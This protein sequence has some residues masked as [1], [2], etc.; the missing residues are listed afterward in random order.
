MSLIQGK[1]ASTQRVDTPGAGKRGWRWW[2]TGG[3]QYL[4][5]GCTHREKIRQ[6]PLTPSLRTEDFQNW[7]GGGQPITDMVTNVLEQNGARPGCLF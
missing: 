2:L 7:E 3:Q 5:L 4:A 6:R 1:N